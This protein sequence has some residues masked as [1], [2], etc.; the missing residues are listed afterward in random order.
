LL[1]VLLLTVGLVA[2]YGVGIPTAGLILDSLNNSWPHLFQGYVDA[3]S[4]AATR[5]AAVTSLVLSITTVLGCAAVGIPLAFLNSRFDFPLRGT[6]A[7]ACVAPL[8]LP[9]LVGA[10]AF[11]FLLGESGILTR[12]LSTGLDIAGAPFQLRGFKAVL[13]FHVYTIFPYFFVFTSAALERMDQAVEEA[14]RTLGAGLWRRLKDVVAP[15]L[16]GALGAAALLTFM[17]SMASFSA[18]YLFGGGMRVLTLEIFE[19]KVN[20]ERQLATVETVLLAAMSLSSLVAYLR[21]ERRV[22]GVAGKGATHRRRKRLPRNVGRALAALSVLGTAVL[23]APHAAVVLVSVADLGAWTT[24]ALPPVY[25]FDH[26]IRIVTDRRYLDPLFNSTIMA[27]AAAAATLLFGLLAAYLVCRFDFHGSRWLEA[28]LLVPWALPGTVLAYQIVAAYSEPSPWTAGAALGGSFWLLPF[29]Y[30]VRT[31]PLA[32]RA[33]SVNMRQMDRDLEP[34]ART[35][36]AG[37]VQALWRVTLPLV[38]PAAW[39]ATFLAFAM[40]AG[41]F[42]ASV[43]AYVYANRPVSI[44]IDQSLRHGDLGSA[45]AYGTV[46]LALVGAALII[47]RRHGQPGGTF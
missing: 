5:Q 2:L 19:A 37:W 27:T 46:L 35:L 44:Q 14:S 16:G 43:V 32:I 18:P 23:V 12:G 17:T 30:F 29:I 38:M 21:L 22:I 7:A 28:C 20:N 13:A 15:G 40:S 6:L 33:I 4:R 10:I 9:P 1:A 3:L 24:Q 47:G 41:E 36:G 42:V 26:Y 25:T 31:M 45:A 34:A 11:V 8:L 39:S